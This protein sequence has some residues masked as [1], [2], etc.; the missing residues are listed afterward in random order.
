LLLVFALLKTYLYWFSSF[1][2]FK[3]SYI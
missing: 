1:Y 2:F 3:I